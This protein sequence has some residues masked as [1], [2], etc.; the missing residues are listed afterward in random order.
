[1]MA[2]KCTPL[3]ALCVCG[4]ATAGVDWAR[5][6]AFC[7]HHAAMPPPAQLTPGRPA[8]RCQAIQANLEVG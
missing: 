6:P 4:R 2:D 3:W 7:L 5:S 1:M 8:G